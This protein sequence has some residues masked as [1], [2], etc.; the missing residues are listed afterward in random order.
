MQEHK[1]DNTQLFNATY[2][3][4]ESADCVEL[5]SAGGY[6]RSGKNKLQC[7]ITATLYY[8]PYPRIE[9]VCVCHAQFD[10]AWEIMQ[11]A[12]KIKIADEYFDVLLLSHVP[13]VDGI[14]Q[15][16]A[17]YVQKTT[18]IV[19]GTCKTRLTELRLHIYNFEQF[20]SH[21]FYFVKEGSRNARLDYIRL[22]Y[23]DFYIEMRHVLK[24]TEQTQK[25]KNSVGFG[26]THVA[27]ISHETGKEFCPS[28]VERHI[29]ALG[30][31]LSFLRGSLNFVPLISGYHNGNLVYESWDVPL[32]RWDNQHN[33]FDVLIHPDGN[34]NYIEEL[35][36]K[37][38]QYI[39]TS[40]D[41]SWSDYEFLNRVIVTYNQ[42]NMSRYIPNSIIL[43]QVALETIAYQYLVLRNQHIS[44][45]GYT[46]LK[47]E[48]DKFR[49]LFGYLGISADMSTYSAVL[50]KKLSN[51]G[52]AK[53]DIPWLLTEMR[54][55]YIHADNSKSKNNALEGDDALQ[56]LQIFL[57][58][59]E[60]TI[61]A[62]IGYS[63]YHRNRLKNPLPGIVERVPWAK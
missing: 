60:L 54:N 36:T 56:Y 4:N 33:I 5:K 20:F 39:D 8:Q 44:K 48:S 62:I 55:A 24:S 11:N 41:N 49:L 27:K 13:D 40:D 58:V 22:R 3:E 61:L 42:A 28:D 1:V 10:G 31:T 46:S 34:T 16:R 37:F 17:T 30:L 25:L 7:Q 15:S 53:Y 59:L 26:I 38:T 19:L 52:K 63:G 6:V 23:K 43:V 2:V 45:D 9:Y 32:A 51:S 29:K 12:T 35:F 21:R 14:G 57:Y 47:Y 18:A 50:A